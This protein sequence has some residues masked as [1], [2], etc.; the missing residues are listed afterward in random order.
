MKTKYLVLSLLIFLVY[1]MPS[2]AQVFEL[3]SSKKAKSKLMS[4]E[5]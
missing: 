2:T 4:E 5:Y 3:S 1:S